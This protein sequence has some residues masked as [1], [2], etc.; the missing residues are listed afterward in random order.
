MPPQNILNSFCKLIFNSNSTSYNEK[1]LQNIGY[2][3]AKVAYVSF[4]YFNT[5]ISL[6]DMISQWLKEEF[7]ILHY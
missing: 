3:P 7:Y 6:I 5:R 2:S 4:N 1:C